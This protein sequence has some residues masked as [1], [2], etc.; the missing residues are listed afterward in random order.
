MVPASPRSSSRYWSVLAP[1]DRFAAATVLVPRRRLIIR[2]VNVESGLPPV[3][4][5]VGGWAGGRAGGQGV[6]GP[7][8]VHP[9][10]TQRVLLSRACGERT[11]ATIASSYFALWATNSV[12]LRADDSSALRPSA[13]PPPPSAASAAASSHAALISS[14]TSSIAALSTSG[15][16]CSSFGAFFFFFDASASSSPSSPPA[17]SSRARARSWRG[18]FEE[19]A[20]ELRRLA[21]V[22]RVLAERLRRRD[23][24]V[25]AL[26]GTCPRP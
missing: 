21:A 10:L 14:L 4:W 15:R 26:V 1:P 5:R 22:L 2:W 25:D 13:T 7:S 16:H 24:G 6:A 17:S 3:R 8:P 9:L 11:T 20:H 19:G 23:L 18:A 12:D